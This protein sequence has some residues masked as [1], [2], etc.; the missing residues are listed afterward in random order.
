MPSRD[1]GSMQIPD[2]VYARA[3]ISRAAYESIGRVSG[4]NH[5]QFIRE[6]VEAELARRK[7]APVGLTECEN[8][9]PRNTLDN[10]SPMRGLRCNGFG[11]NSPPVKNANTGRAHARPFAFLAPAQGDKMAQN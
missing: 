2:G 5:A 9:R 10:R 1:L 7:L 4:G 8:G 11:V 6:A 3:K